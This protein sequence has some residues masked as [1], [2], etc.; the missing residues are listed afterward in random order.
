MEN[1]KF[2]LCEETAE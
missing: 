1:F 2:C